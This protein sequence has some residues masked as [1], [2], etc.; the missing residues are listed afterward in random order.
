MQKLGLFPITGYLSYWKVYTEKMLA[1]AST[2][3][4]I[5]IVKTSSI[6]SNIDKIGS[7]LGVEIKESLSKSYVRYHKEL[8]LKDLVDP[9]YLKDMLYAYTNSIWERI[10]Q[11]SM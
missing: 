4:N 8:K 3:S 5:I 2:M 7:F 1:Y 6:S 11:C 9:N 10:E